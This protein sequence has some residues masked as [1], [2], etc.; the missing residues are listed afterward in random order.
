MSFVPKNYTTDGGNKTVIGGELEI[1]EGARVSGLS[2]SDVF[3]VFDLQGTNVSFAMNRPIDVTEYISVDLFRSAMDGRKPILLRGCTLLGHVFSTTAFA[4]GADDD[5]SGTDDMV[6]ALGGYPKE[7]NTADLMTIVTILL[8]HSSDKVYLRISPNNKLMNL[9]NT[10][11]RVSDVSLSE[12]GKTVDVG[13]TFS[14]TA[15]VEPENAD[16][17]SVRWEISDE[18][19]IT[20]NS[21]YDE[22]A[23]FEAVG[24][25]DATITVYTNDGDYSASCEVMV[26]GSSD[27]EPEPEPEPDPDPE[28]NP[29]EE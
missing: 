19:I 14:L 24:S 16:D 4:V 22:T 26:S 12:T 18:S 8:Y 7:D 9:L 20:I 1:K 28:D 3:T 17:R 10:E 11:I 25:G 13:D 21:E 2:S 5:G 29:E 15:Y 27:D 23:D 6:V